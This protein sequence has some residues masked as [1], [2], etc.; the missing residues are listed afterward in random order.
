MTCI[1]GAM[2]ALAQSP[3][4]KSGTVAASVAGE[5]IY[6]TEVASAV[7]AQLLPLERR[8]YDAKRKALDGLIDR[9]LLEAVAKKKGLT[10]QQLLHE[11]VDA[12]LAPPTN[13]EVE[14]FYLGQ[15]EKL[16]RP[17][18][19][20]KDQLQSAL[21]QA[22]LQQARQVYIKSLRS[23]EDVA[24]LLSPP[25]TQVSYDPSRLRGDANAPVTIVEFSDFQCP[26]CRQMRLTLNKLLAK[27]GNNVSLAYRDFPLTGIH[28]QAQL[29]AEAS[30]CAEDQ[31]QFWDY[32]DRL[33]NSSTLARDQLLENARALKL[34]E[35]QFESCLDSGKHKADVQ[36]DAQDGARAGITGTP[37]LFVNGVLVSGA[38]P[39]E[40]IAREIEDALSRARRPG[41]QA[42]VVPS[43]SGNSENSDGASRR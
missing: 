20:I 5:P 22:R 18:D 43:P 29:A 41:I 14:A 27:Y 37:A 16:N 40:T 9:K 23:T 34:D 25:K 13:A 38:Q 8:E 11:E 33:F 2:A 42:G 15:K 3:E 12:K 28:Q 19:E 30:R 7:R 17:F 1:L 31:G 36:N 35:K 24:V 26:Y 10:I 4:A 6:E 39:E 32:Y 21:V